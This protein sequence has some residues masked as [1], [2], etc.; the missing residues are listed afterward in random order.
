M[1]ALALT[2]ALLLDA[3]LG[4][5]RRAHP[6]VAFGGWARAI[7]ARLHRDARGAGVL[8]WCVTVLPWVVVTW[9]I[10]RMLPAWCD[11]V[12]GAAM[13]YLAVGLRSLG[14]HALPVA[15]ALERGDLAAARTAVGRMVSRDTALLDEQQ[16]AAAATESVLENGS[17]AV[18]G[19]LLWFLLLGAP[20]AVL[21]RLANTLDAMWGY[22]N[23]RYERYGWAAARIDDVLNFVPARLTALSYALL[24]DFLRA[25]HC[26]R[27]QAPAWDSPNAGPVM[28]AGAGA[29]GVRLGGA[30][31]YAGVWEER[32]ALGEGAAP[33][34]AAIRRALRLVRRSVLLWLAA[35][36]CL[37]PILGGRHA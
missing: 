12:F 26:W 23:A 4:E 37:V 7:E 28:A 3:L 27:R 14:E 11:V 35:I 1:T 8:A 17:D 5:P 16:V 29:L 25:W 19:A 2:L 15:D 30:A 32:P 18:F 21:Y 31:P 33:D 10:T 34:A 20:G 13:L 6:L 24:G 36:W 9:A 22:R